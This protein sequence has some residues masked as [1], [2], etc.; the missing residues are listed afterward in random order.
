[1]SKPLQMEGGYADGARKGYAQGFDD[2]YSRGVAAG[3]AQFL[4]P[5]QGTSI[6]IPTY[7]KV[8]YLR[9]C[10]D[11]IRAYTPEPY[12]L[13]IVDNASNDG[14]GEYL[15][16]LQ[17]VRYRINPGN[18]GFA[19]SVNQGLMMARGTTL[20]ILNNDSVVTQGWLSNLLYC[21]HHNPQHGIVGPMTNYIS[22]DQLLEVDYATMTEMQAFASAYNR[23]DPA[24][25]QVT[26]RLT[27]FCMLMRRSTFERLGYFDEGFEI[28]NCEDDDYGLRTRILGEQLII[29]R[30]TFIH[31]YGSVSMKSLEGKF[32]E[33]Y[34]RNLQY[35]ADKWSDPHGLLALG[36]QSGTSVK[37]TE[38]Y[39]TSIVV[40]GPG[41]KLYWIEGGFRYQIEE[42]PG[43]PC[44]QRAVRVSRVDLSGWPLGGVFTSE[45][46][47]HRLA[48]IREAGL[49]G[50]LCDGLVV[51]KPRGMYQYRAGQCH[52][53]INRRAVAG[54]NFT[55]D[56]IHSLVVEDNLPEGVPL[57]APPLIKSE[58]I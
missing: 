14:T 48:A 19:G 2:G 57:I 25:W 8:H 52:R 6:I 28:G 33:V 58:H 40:K 47:L 1:M 22:G 9:E 51:S 56:A 44:E 36:W 41:P 34:G 30:D 42:G 50:K 4:M 20:M 3:S 26:A 18:L 23:P 5:F 27:G 38:L 21:L 16:S 43:G 17:G 54:W 24:A 55:E 10:I 45:E 12:E 7:N 32:D 11:S 35:Y 13:I 53:F 39:P 15:R 49:S 37:T 29:A 46:V 31:H